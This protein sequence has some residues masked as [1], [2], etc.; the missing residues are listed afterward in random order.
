MLRSFAYRL[1]KTD[2]IL[3]DR[4]G[5][6]LDA[7]LRARLRASSLTAAAVLA[8]TLVTPAGPV[9]SSFQALRAS[10]FA[11]AAKGADWIAMR[12]PGRRVRTEMIKGVVVRRP[13]VRAAPRVRR[14]AVRAPAPAPLPRLLTPPPSAVPLAF[15]ENEIAPPGPVAIG[16]FPRYDLSPPVE[17]VQ[18]PP[19]RGAGLIF[20]IGGGGGGVV[21]P[22][23]P[24]A[25][26]EA[27]SWAMMI[28]GFAA[29]GGAWRRR[30]QLVQTLL[31]RLPL[32][33]TDRR[34]NRPAS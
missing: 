33:L 8:A 23:R 13:V 2:V 18:L 31:R 34:S 28:L 7:T 22:V 21:P 27:Q 29:I 16:D 24:P 20:G 4:R 1:D 5:R 30:R 26:P 15:L 14:P 6:A 17:Y 10:A 19:E 25:I 32:L 9:E 3:V 12:S 11:A